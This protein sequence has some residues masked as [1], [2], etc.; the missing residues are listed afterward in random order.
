[1]SDVPDEERCEGLACIRRFWPGREPDLV[2]AS[3]A[4]DSEKIAEAV[5][6]HLHFEP[7]VYSVDHAPGD[8]PRC[9][10]SKGFSQ[11]V[12]ING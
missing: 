1:M 4:A 11:E 2:C 7:V 12:I 6:F 8:F 10:C 5:G 9:V 3:H